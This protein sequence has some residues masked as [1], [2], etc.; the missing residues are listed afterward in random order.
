MGL[1]WLDGENMAG[2][3]GGGGKGREPGGG[4]GGGGG[5]GRAEGLRPPLGARGERIV[6]PG[7]WEGPEGLGIKSESI[8][9]HHMHFLETRS[10]VRLVGLIPNIG[11]N[12]VAQFFLGVWPIIR[13]SAEIAQ[14]RHTSQAIP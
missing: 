9:V 2:K 7:L 1:S 6:C 14:N 4:G 12:P 13:Q 8:A 3:G 11:H 5:R 10:Q